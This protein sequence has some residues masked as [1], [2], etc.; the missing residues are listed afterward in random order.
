VGL[1]TTW[2]L[3]PAVEHVAEQVGG[4]GRAH[5]GHES[6]NHDR[7]IVPLYF[8]FPRPG[9]S[10]V[11]VWFGQSGERFTRPGLSQVGVWFGQSGEPMV[12]LELELP[13]PRTIAAGVWFGQ[14]GEVRL[15]DCRR[16][17]A[18]RAS[19]DSHISLA[20]TLRH[21]IQDLFFYVGEHH[22]YTQRLVRRH[23]PSDLVYNSVICPLDYYGWS[24]ICD[25]TFAPLY[26]AVPT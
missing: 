24:I 15:N 19:A 18:A 20:Y 2:P 8:G 7:A 22:R 4:D 1:R 14:S 26:E 21:F 25:M 10:Q 12:Y 16:R 17:P 3:Y 9:L 6:P 11:G 13:A 5:D 23:I